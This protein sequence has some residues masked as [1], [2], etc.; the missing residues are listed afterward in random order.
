M[1]GQNDSDSGQRRDTHR[2]LGEVEAGFVPSDSSELRPSFP[3]EQADAASP[4]D[5][6]LPSS[7][8]VPQIDELT[9]STGIETPENR[10][11]FD[12]S[13]GGGSNRVSGGRETARAYVA[14]RTPRPVLFHSQDTMSIEVAERNNQ[15]DTVPSL[16]RRK[17]ARLLE[18]AIPGL[19]TAPSE[20]GVNLWF[21][22]GLALF[23]GIF[24]VFLANRE[25]PGP[26]ARAD[27][28]PT[29]PV[30][31]L[32]PPAARLTPSASPKGPAPP[33]EEP[34]VAATQ[35]EPE[36]PEA[37]PPQATASETPEPRAAKKPTKAPVTKSPPA[38]QKSSPSKNHDLWLE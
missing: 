28:A 11:L 33:R 17:V 21:V 12:T 31:H 13:V 20:R 22:M 9:T 15:F 32:E 2:G 30:G 36:E 29:E 19:D 37:P 38:E 25:N 26:E 4:Y 34:K 5:V 23:G 27:E 6:K 1:S 16:S 18:D 10:A 14:P 7:P 8:K 24:L 3:P 35:A